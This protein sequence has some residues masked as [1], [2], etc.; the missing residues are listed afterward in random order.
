MFAHRSLSLLLQCPDPA[1]VA[2]FHES[3]F[4]F[5]L[6]RKVPKEKPHPVESLISVS[7]VLR[8]IGNIR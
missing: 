2:M 6:K 1:V 5:E 3:G 4:G 7:A 8:F